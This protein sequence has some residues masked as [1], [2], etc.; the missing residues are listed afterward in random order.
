MAQAMK[1]KQIL[2][3]LGD[4]LV[5]RRS[6][7]ADADALADFSSRMHSDDGPEKP[8]ERVGVWASDLLKD[9][10]PTFGEGDYTIVEEVKTGKIVSS[11]N[12]ISQNWAYA[13][14]PFKVGRPELVATLPEYRN[15]GLVRQ[16]FDVIH[17]WSAE[18]G[19]VIQA[20]TGIPYYYR[21]FGYEM[22]MNLSGGRAGYRPHLPKLKQDQ[23][24]PY[25]FRPVV[26]NDL[27]F[28]AKTFAYGIQRHLVQC[29]WD[30]DLLRYEIMGKSEKNINRYEF[31][32]I[33]TLEQEPVGF[34]AHPAWTWGQ[35]LPANLFELKEGV[36]WGAVTPSVVRYLLKTGE[37]YAEKDNI[38][39]FDSFG[40]WLGSEHPVYKV[41]ND[42]L[43][44]IRKPYAWYI[45]VPDLPAFLLLI[46]PVLEKRLA[47]SEYPNHTAEIKIT[48]YRG[49]LRL[50]IEKGLLTE[51]ENYQPEPVGHS[52]DAAFPGLT[53]LQILFGYRTLDELRYAFVDCW[54]NGNETAGL[55]EAL[56]P[57]LSSDVWPIS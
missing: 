15:R 10:H 46:R 3:D 34:L 13:G 52:G 23:E 6:T 57:K 1:K 35:M 41:F 36:S 56:F 48:F 5:L 32:I 20:I 22:T 37:A 31:R 7:R 8:D 17:E 24:E 51:I 42:G 40:F 25:L 44:R 28:I 18:R 27:A 21:L 53:F 50:K 12:L 2:R 11:L 29:L 33:E 16:Q 30:K 9:N 39:D 26:E 43:P 54:A 4:G 14:I 19:E 49:G 47:E 45:R 55:L 38:K